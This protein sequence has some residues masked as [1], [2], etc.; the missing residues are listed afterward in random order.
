V[1]EPDVEP[2]VVP[3]VVEPDVLPEVEPLVL[4]PDVLPLVDIPPVL[5]EV[6]PLVLLPLVLPEVEPLVEPVF[7][8]AVQALNMPSDA[9]RSRPAKAKERLFFMGFG[10]RENGKFR[11]ESLEVIRQVA[12]RKVRI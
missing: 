12:T 9:L 8:E 3:V 1:V 4:E 7:S 2:E 6:E 5:P 10:E 11:C